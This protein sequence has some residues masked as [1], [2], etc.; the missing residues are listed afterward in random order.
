MVPWFFR[1]FVFS[2]FRDQNATL[3]SAFFSFIGNVDFELGNLAMSLGAMSVVG[4]LWTS[5]I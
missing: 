3:P 2:A 1:V 4:H 5:L